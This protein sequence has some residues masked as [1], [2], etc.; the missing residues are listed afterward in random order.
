MKKIRNIKSDHG[1]I[2]RT[3]IICKKISCSMRDSAGR[4]LIVQ[5]AKIFRNYVKHF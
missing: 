4:W 3:G 2:I 1:T 5:N